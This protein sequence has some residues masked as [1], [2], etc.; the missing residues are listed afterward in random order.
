MLQYAV[1]AS[2]ILGSKLDSVLGLASLAEIAPIFCGGL[3][4]G[5]SGYIKGDMGST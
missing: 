1:I 5:A 4:L 3:I 2:V